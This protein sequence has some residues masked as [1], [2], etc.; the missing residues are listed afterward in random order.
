MTPDREYLEHAIAAVRMH[1]DGSGWS[2]LAH[3]LAEEV[4]RLWV[5]EALTRQ[6]LAEMKRY[7]LFHGLLMGECVAWN[8]LKE[9]YGVDEA[10]QETDA[11]PEPG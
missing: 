3:T 1:R 6:A 4:E 9:A 7:I 5:R 11:R 8:A 10:F 2:Q